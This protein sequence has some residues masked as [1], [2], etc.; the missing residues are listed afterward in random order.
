MPI[1]KKMHILVITHAYPRWK[2]D[3]SANF[4]ESLC[5]AYVK[6][7]HK[8]TLFVPQT[9]NW[10]RSIADLGNINVVNFSYFPIKKMQVLGYGQ[11]LKNDIRPALF[12]SILMMFYIIHGVFHLIKLLKS[13]SNIDFIH[14]HWAFPNSILAYGAQRLAKTTIPVISSFPG[15]DV[16]ALNKLKFIGKWIVRNII[17]KSSY[18]SCNSHDL[19]DEL[20][21]MGIDKNKLGFV[22]YGVNHTTISE[23]V[24][25]RRLVRDKLN[26]QE[27]DIL[28]LMIGRFVKKKGFSTGLKAM[29]SILV[30]HKNVRLV[31]VGDG[32]LKNEYLNIIKEDSIADHVTFLGYIE[33]HDLY[34]YYSACDIFL[35]PSKRLP[36][37][38]LN[39][40][41][42]EAMACN[43]PIIASNVG[44][45]EL[46]VFD[47][48]NGFLHAEDD[49]IGLAENVNILI[50]NEKLRKKFGQHS[51]KL[52]EDFF[53]WDSISKSY[54]ER[55]TC[56]TSLNSKPG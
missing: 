25:G 21:K 35:M 23:D 1:C 50:D 14:C 10:S 5:L 47:N 32:V 53:N 56:L 8:V 17:N 29:K 27:N 42:V 15:S 48:E 31:I 18:I 20:D 36:A 12:Q 44:G 51:R 41:V 54:V 45:N 43:K 11:A 39:V 49:F 2:N 4:I 3:W 46:V 16:T 28:L 19:K 26:F 52:V 7:G 37:D 9:N 33:L 38:G 30:T 40:T 22:I 24:E 13:E 6:G 55:I 34:K